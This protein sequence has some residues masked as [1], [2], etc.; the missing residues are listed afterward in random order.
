VKFF[1]IILSLLI[2]T[3]S[4]FSF[5]DEFLVNTNE[6]VSVSHITETNPIHEGHHIDP[7]GHEEHHDNKNHSEESDC[8]NECHFCICSCTA[9]NVIVSVF[10]IDF[11][12]LEYYNSKI[13][14]SYTPLYNNQYLDAIF[15]PP[16][17]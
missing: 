2:L 5:G 11:N 1:S 8:D 9:S 7:E 3:S 13:V 15:Q 17:V 6:I 12:I 14:V 16:Q 10:K 4:T